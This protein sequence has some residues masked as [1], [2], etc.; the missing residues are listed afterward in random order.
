M[1]ELPEQFEIPK[2]LFRRWVWHAAFWGTYIAL[3]AIEDLNSNRLGHSDYWK[4]TFLSNIGI[5]ITLYSVTLVGV[6]YLFYKKRYVLFLLFCAVLTL[7]CGWLTV[8]LW[9]VLK[10]S[11]IYRGVDFSDEPIKLTDGL[12]F[13]FLSALF[14][15]ALKVLKDM[16]LAAQ[17]RADR[18]TQN[19]Q[20]ELLALRQ[21]ISP[22]FLLN[23]LNTIYGLAL[24]EPKSVPPTVLA[25][26]DLL[27]FSLYETHTDRVALSRERQFL[28]DYVAMQHLRA[29]EK[30][31]VRFNASENLPN[32]E[33]EIAP[34]LLLV[35]IEN[36]FKYAQPN[37]QG[38]RFLKI[39]MHFNKQNASLDF[40]CTNSYLED[41]SQTRGGVGLD[42]VKRRLA[43]IYPQRHQ[44]SVEAAGGIWR[45]HLIL[46][47]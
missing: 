24:T 27:R 47:L 23:S 2:W 11:I 7:G 3:F 43:L 18:A 37:A 30:L 39:D 28:R 35:F 33:P 12:T 5:V 20:G 44:L 32:P 31:N 1:A 40:E 14:C 15:A 19:L 25:L 13:G 17:R 9:H 42:N 8:V 34:L 6:P 41:T 46:M 4:L 29:S 21:Q 45:V 38:E 10:P 22:H 26:S 16:V 36:A